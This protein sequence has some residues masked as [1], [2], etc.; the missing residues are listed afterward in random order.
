MGGKRKVFIISF[1]L[2]LLTIFPIIGLLDKPWQEVFY[3]LTNAMQIELILVL[4]CLMC[5]LALF[6]GLFYMFQ[7]RN[8]N[9]D[10]YRVA[11]A[12][13]I[14]TAG[15]IYSCGMSFLVEEQAAIPG[16]GLAFAFMLDR[17]KTGE[18]RGRPY[19]LRRLLTLGLLVLIF[20]SASEK[21]L[22]PFRWVGWADTTLG[23]RSPSR[24]PQLKGYVI[25]RENIKIYETITGV[26]RKATVEGDKIYT[27][28]CIP[29]FNYLT[30]C[31][32]P[33]FAPVH[34]WDVCPD[35]VVRK[36]AEVLLLSPPR[37]LVEF[38]ISEEHWK[39]HEKGFRAGKKSGQR[40]MAEA[41]QKL[42]SSGNYELAYEA[43]TPGL[44]FPIRVWSKKT[45]TFERAFDSA[46]CHF[47]INQSCRR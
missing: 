19:C 16:F 15:W 31:P 8:A 21:H 3:K 30:K 41:I 4:S 38:E 36:D 10:R 43:Q 6:G 32:Q 13:L 42:T 28:P 33:T 39:E 14:L 27:F 47:Q 12:V 46:K 7:G 40:I 29:L 18:E 11:L 9:F 2:L 22:Y 5:L 37:V 20:V 25:S 24:E 35:P 17:I 26:I 23:A 1:A 34:Y 45:G 44:D